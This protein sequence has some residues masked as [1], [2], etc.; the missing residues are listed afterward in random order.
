MAPCRT[1]PLYYRLR[2]LDS[3][4]LILSKISELFAGYEKAHG[5][6]DI[7]H[8]N[9]RGK[10]DGRALTIKEPVTDE[11]WSAHLAGR[12]PGLGIVPLREDNTV[13]WGCID[14]D[15]YDIDHSALEAKID[16]LG[17]PLVVA[18]SK[19]GGAHCYLFLTE[20]GSAAIVRTVLSKWSAALGHGG[21]EIFPKQ[22]SRANDQDIGNWLNMPYYH[23][24]KTLRYGI[25]GGKSATLEEFE[26]HAASRQVDPVTL[27]S[28]NPV[29]ADG[30]LFLEGP[31][32]LQHLHGAGGFPE[33]TR[34]DGLYNVA[35]YL[36]KRFP[37]EWK[38]RLGIYNSTMC[39]PPLG[40]AE[41]MNITKSIEKKQY[42]FKCKQ[43]P[44]NAHCDR[45]TC[46]TRQFGV[47]EASLS[48][49][50]IEIGHLVKHVGDPTI[51]FLEIDGRRLVM[52]TDELLNQ[53]A[54]KKKVVD[55]INRCPA[56]LPRARWEKFIDDKIKN[57]DIVEVPMDASPEGQFKLLTE[58]Y[59]TGQ[60]QATSKDELAHRMTPFKTGHGEIWF[61]SRGLFEYLSNH[62][63]RIKS[64]HHVWQMLRDM[65]A[66]SK[67]IT[68]KGKGVNIWVIPEPETTQE[69]APLPT[70]GTKEF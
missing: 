70:F 62:G 69:E 19:S 36:R 26:V 63:F 38:D 66:S 23:A 17:L 22:T 20:P 46:L 57:C 3:E 25:I 53:S 58:Q 24:A 1:G 60:A 2:P 61:R 40:G 50:A 12:G 47:G 56:T 28:F 37:T 64:E 42:A 65:G 6:F 15:V 55:A 44:I 13:W 27:E 31:P 59:V 14:A 43:P 49:Q 5:R 29:V 30:D 54:F 33:G 8:T 16:K 68:V 32:C 9:D 67:F 52:T 7:K 34:N 35:V 48:A 45:T 51:W 21:V 39:V 4:E 41:L 11:L 10:A 18:R